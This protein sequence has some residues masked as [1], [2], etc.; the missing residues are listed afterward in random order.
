MIVMRSCCCCST[1]NGSI[2]IAILYLVIFFSI[3]SFFSI[4]ICDIFPYLVLQFL[5]GVSLIA[6]AFVL[7]GEDYVEKLFQVDPT[8]L[9]DL[10]HSIYLICY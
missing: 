10:S 9:G 3:S 7:T 4:R 1:R 5:T 2:I 6:I 8:A